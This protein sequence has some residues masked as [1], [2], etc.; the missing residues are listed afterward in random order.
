MGVVASCVRGRG[1]GVGGAAAAVVADG[2][3]GDTGARA[4]AG[5]GVA[6]PAAPAPECGRA[7][8]GT[9]LRPAGFGDGVGVPLLAAR[10]GTF[11]GRS[12]TCAWAGA[13]APACAPAGALGVAG[14][15]GVAGL[16]LF[17]GVLPALVARGRAGWVK[18]ATC[19]R[20]AALLAA[21][22]PLPLLLAGTAAAVGGAGVWTR[23]A[24]SFSRYT[25]VP[26]LVVCACA[27]A[28]S[29]WRTTTATASRLHDGCRTHTI[30]VG[31][32]Q[33]ATWQGTNA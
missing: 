28:A 17:L 1:V 7:A 12:P 19:R 21:P 10:R 6:A 25:T 30:A 9:T 16:P 13:M 4:A 15:A 11:A 27:T 32:L 20:P 33:C 23:S 3:A 31:R 29:T 2:T 26:T 14:V 8:A 22:A 5:V 24:P 18:D